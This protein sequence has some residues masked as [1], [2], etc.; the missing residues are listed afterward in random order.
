MQPYST[1]QPPVQPT[2]DDRTFAAGAHVGSFLA[3]WIA[4]GVLAPVLVLVLNGNRSAFVRHHAYESLNFQ[5]NT[6]LW[7][8]AAFLFGVVTFGIG[9]VSFLGIGAWYVVL[10]IVATLAANRGEVYRYP[11]IIRFFQP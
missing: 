11:M 7:M 5:L 4:L 8:I 6:Y 10:V 9:F 3:A 2:S 1:T